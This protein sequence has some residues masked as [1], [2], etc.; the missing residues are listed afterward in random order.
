MTI[1]LGAAIY[2][3]V[4]PV[5][6]IYVIMFVGF[7]IAKYNIVTVETSRGI[8]NMVVNSILPCLTFNKIVAN[9]SD[10]DIKEV[11]VIVLTAIMLFVA[12]GICSIIANFVTSVPRQWFWGLMFAGVFPNISDLPIAYVQSMSNGS[13]FSSD[14][15]DKGVAYCCIFLT[16]QSFL[17]MNFGM[18]RVVGL[19]FRKPKDDEEKSVHTESPSLS[20]EEEIENSFEL[21]CSTSK[22]QHSPISRV[23]NYVVHE[24]ENSSRDG[25]EVQSEID[26]QSSL[27]E[28]ALEDREV[29]QEADVPVPFRRLSRSNHAQRISL[30]LSNSSESVLSTVSHSPALRNP[31]S[32]SSSVHSTNSHYGLP[33]TSTSAKRPSITDEVY[34]R[35][36]TNSTSSGHSSTPARQRRRR[37]SQNVSDVINEYSAVDRI[38]NGELDLSRPLTLTEEVG[39]TNISM[40]REEEIDEEDITSNVSEENSHVSLSRISTNKSQRKSRSKFSQFI[41]KYKLEWL[42]YILVNFFRPASLGALLGIICSMIPWV[43][44]LFVHTDV[45]MHQAPDGQPVLN[46]L[47]DFTQY[48]GNACI[49]LG[50]LMLG[51]TLARLQITK[52][53]KGI[54]KVAALMTFLRLAVLPIIG[55]AW[56]NKIYDMNWLETDIAKFVVILTWAMPSATAQVY[57]TAFYTPLEG[58]H[59]QMDCLSV[60]FLSQYMVLFITLSFVVSYALKVDL[61]L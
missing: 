37:P 52:L 21:N 51:G 5:L 39:S 55:V 19:D 18:F 38:R 44:A 54:I 14:E 1:D 58:D 46:F 42:L 29:S 30:S 7:L 13:V 27:D 17:M 56:A 3:A 31:K 50:L 15:V 43:K 57:F 22:K 20:K 12:G 48:I 6:K 33:Q 10:K 4:K 41:S 40:D 24:S 2:T 32:R 53:P 59:L 35:R 25:N 26:V 61:K 34:Q 8:S 60:F 49:P 45:N 9:I 11:G 28:E 47:M 23:K 36:R 16:S